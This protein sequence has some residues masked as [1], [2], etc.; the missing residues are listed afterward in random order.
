MQSVS[1]RTHVGVSISYDDKHYTTGILIQLL[2]DRKSKEVIE[3][4]RGRFYKMAT[5]YAAFKIESSNE[6]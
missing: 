3:N 5:D 1:F 6:W 4:E 2:L